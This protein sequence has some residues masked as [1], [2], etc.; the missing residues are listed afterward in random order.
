MY[1]TLITL[2][3]KHN[4]S[5]IIISKKYNIKNIKVLER[6]PQ[7]AQFKESINEMFTN[8]LD[9]NIE[10]IKIS[11][12]SEDLKDLLKGKVLINLTGG[13]RIDSLEL[14]KL[15][16]ELNIDRVYL[17]ILEK[18]EYFLGN[19]EKNI[20]KDIDLNIEDILNS[21]GND[22]IYDSSNLSYKEDIKRYTKLIFNNIELWHKYKQRVSDTS[23][24]EHLYKD[25]K[26]VI[27]HKEKLEKE[28]LKL[29]NK[30]LLSLKEEGK[31]KL[32]DEEDTIKVEFLNDYLKGFIFKSGTWLEVF[33]ENII[34][35]IEDIDDVKSGLIF[36]WNK[37]DDVVR[38]ELDVVAVKDSNM[39][40]IS[41][42]DSEKYDENALNE[43]SIYSERLGG[44]KTKKILVSTKKPSKQTIEKRAKEM[45]IHLVILNK[46]REK[47]KN[48]LK[49]IIDK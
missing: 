8:N 39:I 44:N 17:D 38:N 25:P 9:T 18:K 14:F 24:F 32:R 42:K 28:E 41:C 7:N 11:D 27:I 21:G 34:K 23:I 37:Y 10:F 15:S 26:Y 46:D 47:F 1:D 29:L 35:E 43:L 19:G 4:E 33:T 45:G 30:I 3:D 6:H 12:L 5:I 40:C 48:E 13:K 16:L 2:L 36:L 22:L 31:I 49:S 20:L